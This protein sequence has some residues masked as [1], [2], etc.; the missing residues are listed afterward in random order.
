MS[1][2]INPYFILVFKALIKARVSSESTNLIRELATVN[3]LYSG[4][5]RSKS[6]YS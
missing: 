2:I 4:F 5:Q 1:F 6:S 3:T